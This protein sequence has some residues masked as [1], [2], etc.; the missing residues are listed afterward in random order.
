MIENSA[1]STTL[2]SWDCLD[3]VYSGIFVI[4]REFKILKANKYSMSALGDVIEDI[5]PEDTCYKVL[6]GKSARCDDCPLQLE[7]DQDSFERSFVL[8]KNGSGIYLKETITPDNK[9]IFLTF[10]DNINEVFLQKEID[11]I[12]NEIVAKNILLNRHRKGTDE[13]KELEQ[14]ID[15]LPEALVTVD[16]SMNVRIINSKAKLE[17]PV[18]NA[19]KCY[20]LFGSSKPCE[21]C[22]VK[23]SVSGAQDLKTSHV[24][25]GKFFTEIINGFKDGEGGL[26]LFRDNTRQIDLIEKIRSQNETINRKNDI[27][28]T[29]VK[30][31]ARMQENKNIESVLESFIDLFL[32]LYK[33]ESIV[34]IVNDI[35]AGSV[36]F[37][38]S[39]GVN[40]SKV[41]ILTQ[42]YFSRD[43]HTIN[44]N[45]IPE[46]ALPWPDTCQINL[47][48]RTDK[49]VGMVFLEG[50][51][52]EDGAE[53]IDLFKDPLSGY[54]HNMIL[55][56]LLK[57]RADTDSLTSLFN[58]RYL[59]RVME[60]EKNNFEKYGINYSIAV[61]DINGLKNINDSYGHEAGDEIILAVA[62]NLKNSTRATDVVARTGGDEFVALLTNTDEQGAQKYLNKLNNGI[63]KNLFIELDNKQKLHVTISA[64]IA[65]SD[66][67]LPDELLKKA[68]DLMYKNKREFYNSKAGL[69]VREKVITPL[70]RLTA[71]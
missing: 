9:A 60:Q 29:L 18:I 58:R 5:H 49:L 55:I 47:I 32:P 10:Q 20:E 26:L 17:F 64:G 15:N 16:N 41:D 53:I 24:I 46:E 1:G 70:K 6:F 43:I 23:N 4:N 62:R 11:S 37:S 42:A 21:S 31:E 65:A 61:V 25:E 52:A 59:Q 3:N 28:S 71:I 39:R 33:S 56:R 48:G 68:D 40:D 63:F 66:T 45:S 57:E 35:R 34:L 19:R 13:N 30:L 8:N 7:N 67:C 14:L 36:W 38:L 12:K 44:P 54:I 51:G 22:P 27:L 50:K 69:P 2:E